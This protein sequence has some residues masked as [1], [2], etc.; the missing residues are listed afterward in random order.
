M[1]SYLLSIAWRTA[2]LMALPIPRLVGWVMVGKPL[3]AMN[4]GVESE[5]P[6]ST[7]ITS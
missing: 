4:L 7:T 3:S 6:S 2:L 1:A 5:D